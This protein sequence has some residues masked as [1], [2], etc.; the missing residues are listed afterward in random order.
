VNLAFYISGHGYGHAVRDIEIIKALIR[1]RPKVKVHVRTAAP[2]WLF[3][4]RHSGVDYHYAELD[5]GVRQS[6]SFY[7]DKFNTLADYAQLITQKGKI[8]DQEKLFL[9]SIAADLVLSDITPQAFDAARHCSLPCCG[10]GNFSWDWIYQEYLDEFPRFAFVIEDIRASYQK[11]DL[12]F[13][14]PFYGDM[15][16]F[17]TIEDVPLVARKSKIST[18]K[19]RQRIGIPVETRQKWVLLGLRNDDLS[20]VQWDV[21][22]QMNDIVFIKMS[23]NI[24][25]KNSLVIPE[26]VLSFEDI[27]NACDAVLSKPGYSLVSEV[28]AN[29]TPLIYV[30]RKDFAEDPI[31]IAALQHYAVCRELPQEDYWAG[32]WQAAFDDL[33]AQSKYWPFIRCDGADVVS[34]KIVDKFG[35]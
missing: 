24:P 31:L 30:P 6:N 28:I 21:V 2:Q 3:E 26:G 15:S 18:S 33:F 5:F 4:P 11:A 34:E 23:N 16:A 29:Q 35:D 19:T 8:I 1:L 9:D 20:G 25:L 32:R 7:A 12:L 17:R 13:R 14:I 22:N 27:L 10:I